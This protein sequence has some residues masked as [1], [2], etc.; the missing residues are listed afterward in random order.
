VTRYS[1]KEKFLKLFQKKTEEEEILPNLF[2]ASITL[3]TKPDKNTTEK[4]NCRPISLMDIDIKI[5]NKI[6]AI[7]IK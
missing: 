4:E 2:K 1:D 6:L 7:Q 5:L 3:M